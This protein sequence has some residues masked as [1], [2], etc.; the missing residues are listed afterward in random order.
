MEYPGVLSLRV[1]NRPKFLTYHQVEEKVFILA[2]KLLHLLGQN[3]IYQ[4]QY[5]AIPRGGVFILGM[6]AYILNI[7]ASL[8]KQNLDQ[9]MPV[10]VLD[11]CSLSGY[12]FAQFRQTLTDGQ[13]IVFAPLFSH[14]NLRTAILSQERDVIACLS[15]ENLKDLAPEI[16]PTETAYHAWRQRWETRSESRLYW[17]GLPE[18]VVFP[19]NE[20]DQPVWNP[21]TQQVEDNWRF[22]SPDR[23]LKNWGRLGLPP[24]SEKKVSVRVPDGVAYTVHQ[25]DIT[26]CNLEDE[27]MYGL[28]GPSADIWRGLAAYGDLTAA[29]DYVLE[30]YEVDAERLTA[31][32][33][34]LVQTLLEKGLLEPVNDPTPT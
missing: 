33:E 32:I 31:D 20:P 18:V 27:T 25:G 9:S 8:I 5:V 4:F 23:C 21:E 29:R 26:L 17:I 6:L 14:P 12:R 2:E 30:L 19:W 7:P 13:K 16:Y 24:R 22:T 15:A 10:L 1:T 3:E 34:S 28:A 11:D